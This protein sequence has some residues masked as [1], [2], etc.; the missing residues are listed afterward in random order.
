[1]VCH[2]SLVEYP[3]RQ[4]GELLSLSKPDNAQLEQVNRAAEGIQTLLDDLG[5]PPEADRTSLVYA[6]KF[7]Q[8][9]FMWLRRAIV[10]PR[11]F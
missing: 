11:E 9:G 10:K 6:K 4:V 2:S 7:L 1:M 8:T 3:E 5:R